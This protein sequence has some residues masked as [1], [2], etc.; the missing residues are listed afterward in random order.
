VVGHYGIDWQNRSITLAYWLREE[1]QGKGFTTA[2]CRVL[3]DHVFVELGLN[4]VGIAC[5]VENERSRA[6][7]ERLGFQ[8]EG[9]QRQAEWLYDHLVNHTV[10][11]ALEREWGRRS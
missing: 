9:V 7:P 10:Y 3:V 6:V 2:A 4:W 5:V 1:D 11:A 8:H